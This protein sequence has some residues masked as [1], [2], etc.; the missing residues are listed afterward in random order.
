MPKW[1]SLS[2]KVHGCDSMTQ[3]C[4]ILHM[5]HH[6]VKKKKT[7][8]AEVKKFLS[9]WDRLGPFPRGRLKRPKEQRPLNSCL[10]CAAIPPLFWPLRWH[11]SF[12]RFIHPPKKGPS[13]SWNDGNFLTLT[14]KV[15]TSNI[16]PNPARKICQICL[17]LNHAVT[18]IYIFYAHGERHFNCRKL[19]KISESL[20]KLETML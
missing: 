17:L 9:F 8:L 20:K 5:I 18:S 13:R 1:V 12:G 14:G 4:C 3:C 19:A 16:F 10:P 7:A 15:F 2:K 11:Y 6:A